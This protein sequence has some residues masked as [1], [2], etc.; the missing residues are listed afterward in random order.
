MESTDLGYETA[1]EA[2]PTALGAA[3]AERLMGQVRRQP[4]R[5]LTRATE[6]RIA[7]EPPSATSLAMTG[8]RRCPWRRGLPWAGAVAGLAA[9][10]YFLAPTV[11]TMLDT[12]STDDAYVSGHVD[13][14]SPGSPDR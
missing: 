11:K 14:G 13:L 7:I 5:P 2:R 1:I 10:A 9:G 4:T 6:S 3:P 8:S 12:V